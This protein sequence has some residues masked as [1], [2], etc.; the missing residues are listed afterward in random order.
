MRTLKW[1]A[2]MALASMIGTLPS[3]GT[4]SGGG[5]KYFLNP[6]L[7]AALDRA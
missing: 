2:A 4:M 7:V 6:P 5:M 3:C 1:L